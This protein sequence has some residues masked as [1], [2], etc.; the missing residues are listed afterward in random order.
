MLDYG[1][2]GNIEQQSSPHNA[3][4][5]ISSDDSRVFEY[6]QGQPSDLLN[7][8]DEEKDGTPQMLF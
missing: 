6:G 1:V 4:E 3:F 2:L 7:F 5:S 8:L